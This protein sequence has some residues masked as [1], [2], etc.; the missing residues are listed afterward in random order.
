[1]EQGGLY[2]GVSKEQEQNV[3]FH[4]DRTSRKVDLL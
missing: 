4:I 2:D 1:M 3:A